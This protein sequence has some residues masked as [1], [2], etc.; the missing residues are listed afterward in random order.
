MSAPVFMSCEFERVGQV[1]DELQPVLVA[2]LR[3]VIGL[4]QAAGGTIDLRHARGAPAFGVGPR[5]LTSPLEP[6]FVQRPRRQDRGHAA[7]DVLHQRVAVGA[8]LAG[9][10]AA[11]AVAGR[12]PLVGAVAQLRRVLVV[13]AAIELDERVVPIGGV[14]SFAL[15]DRHH[16]CGDD[17]RS[18][19]GA[20]LR[21]SR[22]SA[23]GRARSARR[24]NRQSAA[25]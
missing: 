20:S 1:V 3:L 24:G 19:A 17:A 23:A 12:A 6:E 8:A 7:D 18:R 10:Q 16:R 25:G 22:N 21:R 13:H 15:V 2:A 9:V 11:D 14:G 4:A 5:R